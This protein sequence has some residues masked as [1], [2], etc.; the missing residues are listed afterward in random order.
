MHVGCNGRMSDGGV[1][2]ETSLCQDLENGGIQYGIPAPH[3]LPGSDGGEPMPYVLVGDDA[4]GLSEHL[5]KPYPRLVNVF[6][7]HV[8]TMF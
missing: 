2:R 8:N 1:W 5:M 4:F 6:A 3:P 7:E